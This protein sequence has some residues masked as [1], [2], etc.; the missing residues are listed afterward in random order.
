MKI[1][2][3]RR[4][5]RIG[6]ALL[7][8]AIVAM[9]G[10]V[11]LAGLRPSILRH[12]Q[13]SLATFE[14]PPSPPPPPVTRAPI[15]AKPDPGRAA[16][17]AKKALASPV[18]APKPI[19]RIPPRPIETVPPVAASG[20]SPVSGASDMA[21]RGT[22]G[23]GEGSGTGSGGG[24]NGDGGGIAMRA[25]KIAG[26]IRNRDYPRA[27]SRAGASGNVIV[28][29]TVGT[30]GRPH[31]CRTAVSSGNAALDTTTCRLIEQRFRYRPAVNGAG[32]PVPELRAW[33]QRWWFA[34]R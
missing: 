10:F 32:K 21:D 22:G 18:V 7:S 14:V 15:R 16:P 4:K 5:E 34:A 24:G 2:Q 17:L 33:Q 30:D 1:G 20:E 26:E 31:G 28:Q 11:L 19:V 25:E 6:A 27:A 12:I 9:L 29:F 13:P 8:C 3:N 23:G